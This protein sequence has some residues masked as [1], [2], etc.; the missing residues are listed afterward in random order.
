MLVQDMLT[1]RLH[2]VRPD[3]GVAAPRIGEMPDPQTY[4]LGEV[5]D[6][7]GNSLGM[8]FLPKLIGGAVNAI[9]GGG[10]GGGLLSRLLPGGGGGGATS[11]PGPIRLTCPPCPP[12]PS[13]NSM[14]RPPMTPPGYPYPFPYPPPARRRRRR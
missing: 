10:G 3:P 8:F 12:C 7:L 6:G 1:G 2:E 13:P 14:M 11:A 5:Y 4:G 9:T